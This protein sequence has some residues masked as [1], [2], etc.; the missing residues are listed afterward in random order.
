MDREYRDQPGPLGEHVSHS[1]ESIW[2]PAVLRQQQN[3]LQQPTSSPPPSFIPL[4]PSQIYSRRQSSL[5][6]NQVSPLSSELQ[7]HT[8]IAW[9]TDTSAADQ[10]APS[11]RQDEQ[12]Q[13]QPEDRQAAA[14][15]FGIHQPVPE[16][17]QWAPPHPA[18]STPPQAVNR[19]IT[20]TTDG[21][22]KRVE[23]P[24]RYCLHVSEALQHM[25]TVVSML[26]NTHVAGL[27]APFLSAHP[28]RQRSTQLLLLTCILVLHVSAHCPL[29]FW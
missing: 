26:L 28:Y 15:L 18:F 12:R 19:S 20:Y 8:D 14:P 11:S 3:A 6:S 21:Q 4:P 24:S 2:Q 13:S 29:T 7:L 16:I 25:C 22:V 9:T 10:A 1:S 17:P 5:R 27:Q 23:K